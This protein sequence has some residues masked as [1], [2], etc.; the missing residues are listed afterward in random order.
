MK[1]PSFLCITIYCDISSSFITTF[2]LPVL[3]VCS[4][5]LDGFSTLL[6]SLSSPR[7]S[8]SPPPA[9]LSLSSSSSSISISACLCHPL[10]KHTQTHTCQSSTH[11][12]LFILFRLPFITFA[13]ILL[14]FFA[15]QISF[16]SS[17]FS[18]LLSFFFS[19]FRL[20]IVYVQNYLMTWAS[21][22]ISPVTLQ[23]PEHKMK[24]R[25]SV[26]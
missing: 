25:Y 9:S 4:I 11:F 26:G 7:L 5:F 23:P 14:L 13:T 12:C 15:F 24:N 19:F 10:S 17:Y 16:K 3:Y 18:S 21:E 6:F 8:F 2:C 1:V 20:G 22:D